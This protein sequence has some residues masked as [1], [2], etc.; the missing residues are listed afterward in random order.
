MAGLFITG[1][2]TGVGKTEVTVALMRWLRGQG[3]SVVGMKPVASGCASTP[4]GLRNDDALRLLEN[5]SRPLDYDEVNPYAFEL[6][7]SPHLAA[8]AASRLV[9]LSDIARRYREL[10]S[11]VDCVLVEGIGGWETP[12]GE[13]ER[14]SDLARALELPAVLVVGMRL[15]CLNHA[16]LTHEA[17]LRSGIECA[18]WIA[19]DVTGNMACMADIIETLE[20]ELPSYCLGILPYHRVE[21]EKGSEESGKSSPFTRLMGDE[22]LRR[23]DL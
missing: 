10:A 8:R 15:G 21:A 7:I 1:T 20:L 12:L 17:I 18:G 6:P 9:D 4:A 23:F 14:V 22:I 11:T 5:A 2:D 13:D 16:F 19:N 3:L